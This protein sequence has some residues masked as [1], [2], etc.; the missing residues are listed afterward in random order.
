M[1]IKSNDLV[2]E[3]GSG[4]NPKPRSD[5][6]CDKLPE[7]DTERGGKI[8]LDRPFLACDGQFLPFA[9][10]SF[11]YIICCQVLEHAEEPSIFISEL[12]RVGKAGFIEVPTEISEKLYGWEYHKWLFSQDNSGKLLIKKK[13]Q[14]NQFGQLFHQLY[15]KDQ[16]YR[17]FHDEYYNILMI[18]YEWFEKIDYEIVN[19]DDDLIDLDNLANINIL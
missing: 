7:D 13:T 4:H 11:D 18:Q 10:K 15:L 8:V 5:V 3:I 9:D 2:L 12:M 17:K 1:N 19:T 16:N 14:R 6:L